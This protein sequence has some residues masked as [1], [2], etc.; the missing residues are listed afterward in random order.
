M[1]YGGGE[2]GIRTLGPPQ[3]G[4]RFSRPP[5]STAP[6][7]LHPSGGKGLAC[8]VEERQENGYMVWSQLGPK[9]RGRMAATMPAR[10]LIRLAEGC[11][12]NPIM[13]AEFETASPSGRGT[14]RRLNG[15]LTTTA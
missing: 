9:A 1:T 2:G 11:A 13:I 5:R 15:P 10:W 4:Q 7:P 6:A 8:R 12:Q 3:G 14:M